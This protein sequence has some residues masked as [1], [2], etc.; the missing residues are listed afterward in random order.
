MI[1]KTIGKLSR[2]NVDTITFSRK[3]A[4]IIGFNH[5]KPLYL[6]AKV[7]GVKFKRALVGNGS[8]VNLM[9]YQTFKA[10]G[11]PEKRLV[12]HSVPLTTFASSSFTTKCHVNVDLQVGPLRAP[13]K[14]YVIEAD[15]SYCILLGRPWIYRNYA[16]PSTLQKC[17]K[18][19]KGRKEI[20]ISGTKTPFSHE[21]VHWIEAT[22]FDDVCNETIEFRPR[23]VP[24]TTPKEDTDM[25]IDIIE[26]EKLV[27]ERVILLDR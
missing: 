15:V 4:N 6:E 17:L 3:D 7:N 8:L 27:I 13:T 9:S 21:K 18:V 24:L 26:Q 5:N 23:G 20:L 2:Q 19:I 11:I 10:V 1:S 16:I 12:P 25:E 14:F 22:F